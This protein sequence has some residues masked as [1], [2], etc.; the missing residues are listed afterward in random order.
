VKD[1]MHRVVWLVERLGKAI[2][3]RLFGQLFGKG[4]EYPVPDDEHHAHIL[5]QVRYIAGVVHAVVRWGNEDIRHPARKAYLSLRM[6]QYAVGL[7]DGIHKQDIYRRKPQQRQR[8]KIQV[9]LK[10]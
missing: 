8:N 5:I 2:A 3:W 6:H 1:N 10:R 9:T 7:R 4:A